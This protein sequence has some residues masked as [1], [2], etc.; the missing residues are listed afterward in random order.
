MTMVTPPERVVARPTST[1]RDHAVGYTYGNA[2]VDVVIDDAETHRWLI[3]FL[4]PWA[5]AEAFTGCATQVRFTAAQDAWDALTRRALAAPV[6][7]PCFVLDSHLVMLPGWEDEH[8]V[9]V[10]DE[11]LGCFYCV[12]PARVDIVARPG[13]RRA[14][15]GLMRVVRE[16]LTARRLASGSL[17]DLHAAA[18]ETGQRAVLIA[19]P[20]NAG[21]TT[22]LCHALASGGARMI[23][24]DRVLV[25]LDCGDGE[26]V[27]VPTLASARAAT[28]HFFPALRGGTDSLPTLLHGGEGDLDR[29]GLLRGTHVRSLS[30][31]AFAD[32]LGSSCV[33]TAP[34]AAVVF[35]EIVADIDTWDLQTL[36]AADGLAALGQ[37]RYGAGR[38]A[39]VRTIFARSDEDIPEVGRLDAMLRRLVESTR[40]F[41]CRLGP[42]AYERSAVEWLAALGLD[43]DRQTPWPV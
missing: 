20:R 15:L 10:E 18:F 36:S 19:G 12:R 3:D 14:R 30:L 24:N 22:M 31:G 17:L 4:T 28:L 2:A 16:L 38:D 33:A 26:V 11:E 35:P 32:R 7:M 29:E 34:L 37:C 27:G 42:R 8:G 41:R 21:K 1:G 23:A 13:E 39:S 25:D 5:T 9:A 43:I 6:P 40:V